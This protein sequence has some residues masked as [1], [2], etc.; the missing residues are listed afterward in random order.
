MKVNKLLS[1]NPAGSGGVG[2]RM[3]MMR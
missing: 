1:V 3:L 2:K